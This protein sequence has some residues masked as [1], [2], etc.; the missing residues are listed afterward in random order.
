MH[1]ITQASQWEQSFETLSVLD[2]S[3][4]LGA[5]DLEAPGEAAWW[6]RRLPECVSARERAVAAYVADGDPRRAAIVALRL[7]YTS[8]VRG[9][10]AIATGWLRRAS[11][12]LDDQSEGVAHGHLHIAGARVARAHGE[13]QAEL[14]HASAAI[15]IGERFGDP[16]LAAL[17]RYIEGRLL[18]RQGQVYDGMATLDE[19][20]LAAVQGE[21]D[22]MTT[23]QVYCNVIA[24]SRSSAICA[25]PAS[26]PRRCEGGVRPSRFRCFPACALTGEMGNPTHGAISKDGATGR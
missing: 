17:G 3:G 25:A 9:E 20:M 6:L 21:L 11:R 7:F 23:G 5:E 22:P 8:F 10:E 24:A 15:A 2:V 19:A 18:V 4:R 16:D 1:E 14:D 26:G 12:L 13:L